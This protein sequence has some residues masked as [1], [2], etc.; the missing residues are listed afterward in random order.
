VFR[1]ATKKKQESS[2]S[3][4]PDPT[5]AAYDA[6]PDLLVGWEGQAPSPDPTASTLNSGQASSTPLDVHVKY[7]SLQ[8]NE[9]CE[10][11]AWMPGKLC[12]QQQF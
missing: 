9:I 11:Q 8:I 6:P 7:S 3:F 5:G 12:I 10:I 4:S 1:R 2:W